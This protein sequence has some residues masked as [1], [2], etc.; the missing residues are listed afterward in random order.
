[1]SDC[2]G[3]SAPEPVFAEPW[4]AQVFALTVQLNEAGRFTWA[5]WVQRFSAT[6]KR[7]GLNRELDGGEDYFRAW[8]ETLE[9]VL[10]DDGTA[11]RAEAEGMRSRW[12]EAYLSTPH[13]APVH[14]QG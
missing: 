11:S 14:L 4:H 1:M 6:L 3:I 9:Q 2:A 12:E 10:A 8:L 5:D 7:H 13:G